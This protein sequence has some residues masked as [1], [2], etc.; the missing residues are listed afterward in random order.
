MASESGAAS[1]FAAVGGGRA[2][3]ILAFLLLLLIGAA[4]SVEGAPAPRL[5][6][7]AT[8]QTDPALY[9]AII[10]DLR[11]GEPYYPA[12]ARELRRG[13]YPLRP[14]F[15]VRLPTTAWA[16]ARLGAGMMQVAQWLLMAAIILAWGWRARHALPRAT[17]GLFLLL[18]GLGLIGLVQPT[19]G[20]FPETWSAML[21]ALAI[22]LDRPGGSRWAML[23][24]L[25]AL[26]FRELA[27]PMVLFFATLALARRQ[28]RAAIGWGATLLFFAIVMAVHATAVS[29]VVRPDDLPSPGWS[30]LLG[31]GFALR[32]LAMATP[33]TLLPIAVGGPLFALSLFG[34]L[35]SRADWALRAAAMIVGYVAILAL[36]ARTDN[37]YWALMAAPL[38]LAGLAFVPAA[39]TELAR[40]LRR[41]AVPRS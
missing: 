34:W 30:G 10:A 20:L 21:L 14:F 8:G 22:A 28:W 32:S 13:H 19:V 36:F 38:S 40:A 3:L 23:A 4:A 1:R 18:I 31:P 7:T 37:F 2:S 41:V 16:Y 39:I 25:A 26:L 9:R 29:H 17:L 12:A 15:T 35:S 6:A 5:V 11:A 24:A 27:M 33:A